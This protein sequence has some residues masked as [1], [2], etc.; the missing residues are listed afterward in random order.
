MPLTDGVRARGWPCRSSTAARRTA[1]RSCVA[2]RLEGE[3]A[4]VEIDRLSQRFTGRDVPRR[5]GIVLL[6]EVEHERLLELPFEDT[7][8]RR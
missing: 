2:G 6:V 3:E 7:P 8:P 4:L 1:R 5:S